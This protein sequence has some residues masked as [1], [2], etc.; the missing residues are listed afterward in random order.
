MPL[1]VDNRW[2]PDPQQRAQFSPYAGAG[3]RIPG[4]RI[5]NSTGSLH[6][7]AGAFEHCYTVEW[8]YNGGSI[9]DWFCPGTGIVAEQFDHFGTPF[10]FR[11]ELLHFSA[12]QK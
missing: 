7:P 5:V 9:F 1:A 8:V 4:Y 12:S 6:V 11:M 10:G 2:Y 3:E